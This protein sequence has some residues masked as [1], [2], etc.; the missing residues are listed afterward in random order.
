MVSRR[1]NKGKIALQYVP[2]SWL[3]RLAK[4]GELGNDEYEE[5]NRATGF[6]KENWRESIGTDDHDAFLR[7][8]TESLYRHLADHLAYLEGVK[9]HPYDEKALS[10]GKKILSLDQIMFNAGILGEYINYKERTKEKLK[11]AVKKLKAK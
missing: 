8:R 10:Q 11:A 1:N 9:K 2:S 5:G 7:D 6:G 3:Y 4:V